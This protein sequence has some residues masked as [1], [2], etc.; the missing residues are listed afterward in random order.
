MHRV[1]VAAAVLSVGIVGAAFASPAG[2]GERLT[3]KEFR[4]EANSICEAGNVALGAVFDAAFGEFSSLSEVPEQVLADAVQ[5]A[6]GLF[7]DALDDVEEV[8]GPAA[9]DK[10]VDKVLDRYR[11]TA[12]EIADDPERAFSDEDIWAQADKAARKLGLR[13]CVQ[14]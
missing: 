10:K 6:V 8:E 12:D 1:R 13:E 14:G 2:A 7:R 9:F 3:K 4:Q 5:E 11:D